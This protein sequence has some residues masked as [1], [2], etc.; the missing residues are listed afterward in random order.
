MILEFS[1]FGI[2]HHNLSNYAAFCGSARHCSRKHTLACAHRVEE[3]IGFRLQPIG[4]IA[5]GFCERLDFNGRVAGFIRRL[6]DAAH[7]V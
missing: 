7:A 1:S 6:D 3:L 2:K 5:D 4:L